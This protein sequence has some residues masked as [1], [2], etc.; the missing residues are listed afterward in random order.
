MVLTR[1]NPNALAWLPALGFFIATPFYLV[2]YMMPNI[3]V[4]LPFLGAEA[5]AEE[6]E[7]LRLTKPRS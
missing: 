6:R 5:A 7:R 4:A 2:G 1:P 3:W